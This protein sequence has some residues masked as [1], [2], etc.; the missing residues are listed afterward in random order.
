MEVDLRMGMNDWGRVLE[1]EVGRIDRD[2]PFSWG[3]DLP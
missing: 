2:L 1:M 3:V